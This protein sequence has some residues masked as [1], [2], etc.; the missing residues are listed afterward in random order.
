MWLGA[1]LLNYSVYCVA[2]GPGRSIENDLKVDPTLLE[3]TIIYL[4]ATPKNPG[5]HCG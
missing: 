3:F 4:V 2:K 1:L 5:D